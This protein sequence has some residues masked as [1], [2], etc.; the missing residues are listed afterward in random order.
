MQNL[1]WKKNTF[2]KFVI[3]IN[4]NI[5][6]DVEIS[7]QYNHPFNKLNNILKVF[8]WYPQNN[9]HMTTVICIRFKYAYNGNQEMYT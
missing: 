2:I 7:K 4:L 6:C 1:E 5:R 8:P 3:Q 9:T